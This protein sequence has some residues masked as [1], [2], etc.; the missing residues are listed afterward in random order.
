[1][2]MSISVILCTHNPQPA[3]LRRTLDA[4]CGQTLPYDRWELLFVDNASKD[5]LADKWDISWHP[6]GRHLQEHEI[7]LTAARLRGIRESTGELLVFV[8]DDNVLDPHYLELSAAIP[9]RYPWLG[10]FGC[11]ALE[12]EFQV[13]PS[14]ELVSR[15]ALLALRTVPSPVWSNNTKDYDHLPWGAGLC[16]SR[17]VSSVYQELLARL[18][19]TDVLDRRGRQLTCGGDDLFSWAAL[20]DGKGFGLFPE[21]RLTHLISEGRLNRRYFLRLIGDSAFSHGVLNYMLTGTEPRQG[22]SA[23]QC[24]RLL[25][26]G[27]KNGAFS[28]RCEWAAVKGRTRAARFV[29]ENGL[30]PIE[31]PPQPSTQPICEIPG[32]ILEGSNPLKL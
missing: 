7:G 16:V 19:V 3:C 25:L 17:R 29:S 30:R 14:P 26:H 21:L 10:V 1:M 15:L 18:K 23:P 8:D 9:A 13:P 22:L 24:V 12:P 6:H 4:L 11:G 27:I 31:H 28:M 20:R 32:L 5:S 2:P